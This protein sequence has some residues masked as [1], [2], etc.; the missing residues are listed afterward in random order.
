MP[1]ITLKTKELEKLI[2]KKLP[3]D[4]LRS[5]ISYLGTDIDSIDENEIIVEIFPNRPDMLSQQG[6]ARALSSFLNIK[7]GLKQYKAMKSDYKV[8]IDDSVKNVRPYTAC[9]IIKNLH[10][11]DEKI[12]DIIQL[13]EKLHITFGR[14]RKK[15]AIGIYPLEKIKFPIYYLAKSSDEIKFKPLDFDTEMTAHQILSRHPTGR[16]YSSLLLNYDKYPIF[17]DSNNKILS[18]PPIINSNDTGKVTIDTKDVFIECSGFDFNVLSKCLNI[19]VTS[20]ADMNST[21]HE[22]QLVYPDKKILSPNL[23]STNINININYVNKILGLNLKENEIKNYLERM[24]YSYNKNTVLVPCYRADILHEIDL[25][26][27]IAI[28]YGYEN[29]QEYIPK[30]ATIASEDKFERLK[31]KISELLI[32]LNLIEV[33]TFHLSNADDQSKKMSFN[34]DFIELEN[35]LTKDYNV[36]RSWLTPFL[37]QILENN[38][39]YS[40]PQNIFEIATCF[41]INNATETN[42]E[43]FSDLSILIS[44]EKANFTEIKQVLDAIF[45]A[46]DIKYEIKET[47]H[48]SFIAGR[49][50]H[51]LYRDREIAFI[52]EIHPIVLKNFN[53]EMPVVALELN[54]IELFNR[55][56]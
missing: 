23:S 8:I 47:E 25:V 7:P 28:A 46:L 19:I 50:G 44:H 31:R 26:E 33:N 54:L 11:D 49:V 34:S 35:A 21:I 42:T 36:L 48:P 16:E 41:K 22:M 10:L 2:N 51:V 38:K 15:L 4:E 20:L 27:D 53:L 5:R 17:I 12:R 13:Q 45:N 29:F 43:E 40:Y 55:L 3:L 39:L 9:S 30:V 14:N 24:G 52:G 1:T 18:M 56:D 6:F 37:L 32:G